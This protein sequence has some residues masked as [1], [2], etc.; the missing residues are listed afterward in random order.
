MRNTTIFGIALIAVGAF[1]FFRGGSF[2]TR[3]D[4]VKIGDLKVSADRE[5][6]I[7]PWVAGVAVLA[8]A[9]LVVTGSRSKA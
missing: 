4:V 5:H 9:V 8:G 6:S 7:A 2:T 1:L 3:E